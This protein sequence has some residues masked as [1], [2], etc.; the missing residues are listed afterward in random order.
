[1]AGA[2]LH[3][4]KGTV[5]PGAAPRRL[6]L[7][8][9][10]PR[11]YRAGSRTACRSRRCR[12]RYVLSSR[13][14]PPAA[15]RATQAGGQSEAPGNACHPRPTLLRRP[16]GRWTATTHPRPSVSETPALASS[17]LKT[18]TRFSSLVHPFV[19]SRHS[20]RATRRASSGEGDAR[21]QHQGDEPH[22]FVSTPSTFATSIAFSV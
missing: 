20:L 21:G 2:A 11:P 22:L 5:G 14:P 10:H 18:G 1:M 3:L 15:G 9:R 7:R 17:A 8:R 12:F 13:R 4:Q 19:R 16:R 6:G